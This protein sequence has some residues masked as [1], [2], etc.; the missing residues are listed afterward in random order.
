[1]YGINNTSLI[2]AA[3]IDGLTGGTQSEIHIGFPEN[4]ETA[5]EDCGPE[6]DYEFVSGRIVAEETAGDIGGCVAMVVELD[7]VVIRQVGMGEKLVD[8]NIAERAGAECI[9]TSR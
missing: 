8:D 4:D 6:W 5:R 2:S 3:K 1:M 9:H 7:V